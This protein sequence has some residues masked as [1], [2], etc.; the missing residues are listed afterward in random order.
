MEI[1]SPKTDDEWRIYYE[2]RYRILREPLGQPE[3]SERNEGDLD[4]IHIALFEN[5]QIAAI[6][7]LDKADEGYTGQVRFVAVGNK[8][9]GNGYGRE[10]MD[11]AEIISKNRGDLKMVLQARENSVDFYISLGYRLIKKTHLLFDQVQH[12]LM[13]KEYN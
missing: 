8:Y 6:A 12:F 3:G 2:L 7:R 13:V 4:G 9:Q 11:H 5:N 1:R 10:I